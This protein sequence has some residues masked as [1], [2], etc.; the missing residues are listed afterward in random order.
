MNGPKG[1]GSGVLDLAGD[2]MDELIREAVATVPEESCGLVVGRRSG[3][4]IRVTRTISCEN[5]ALPTERTYRF[6]IDP[7]R[8]LAEERSTRGSDEEVVGFY[9]SHP[10]SDPIPSVVDRGYMALW[11]DKVWVIVR[12]GVGGRGASVR[13]WRIDEVDDESPREIRIAE[14]RSSSRRDSSKVDE[15]VRKEEDT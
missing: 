5:R 12:P 13:A 9:H 1:F 2:R 10:D 7:R 8:L 3:D 6:E 4:R 11:P 15:G 14:D